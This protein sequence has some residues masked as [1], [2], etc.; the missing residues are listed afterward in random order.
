LTKF[1]REV[2]QFLVLL[3]D[4][5]ALV[6]RFA[7]ALGVSDTSGIFRGSRLGG[8]ALALTLNVE[9]EEE[10][11]ARRAQRKCRAGGEKEDNLAVHGL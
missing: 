10:E 9:Q 11:D 1:V 3:L 2:G 5:A 6:L 8:G 7:Q 4:A